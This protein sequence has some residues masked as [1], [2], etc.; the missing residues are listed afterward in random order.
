MLN[1]KIKYPYVKFV[2]D[3][4]GILA[5]VGILLMIVCN[6]YANF[7]SDGNSS[8]GITIVGA[9]FMLLAVLM[10][11]VVVCAILSFILKLFKKGY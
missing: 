8:F 9:N 10:V 4:V 2:F 3:V 6:T 11:I 5:S 1:K 7:N